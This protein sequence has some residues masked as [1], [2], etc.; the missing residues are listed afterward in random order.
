MYSDV[1]TMDL[2]MKIDTLAELQDQL[3]NHEFY[4]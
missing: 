3:R 2:R 4:D 1:A